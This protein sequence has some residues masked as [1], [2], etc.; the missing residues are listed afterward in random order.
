MIAKLLQRWGLAMRLRLNGPKIFGVRPTVTIGPEDFGKR[1]AKPSRFSQGVTPPSIGFIYVIR[2]EH[3]LIKV[4]SSTNPRARLAQ[5]R[6]A[7]PFPLAIDYLGF[8]RADLYVDV[9][10]T[11]H[12]ILEDHRVNLEWFDCD[13][14]IAVAAIHRAAYRLGDHV[15]TTDPDKTEDLLRAASH[16]AMTDP[17]NHHERTWI[18]KIMM[19]LEVWTGRRGLGGR[20]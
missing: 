13:S 18:D 3:G 10:K 12:A 15:V 9:E 4:G 6:T 20:P 1:M 19:T 8:T 17:D 7:S 16:Q 14:D 11:A 2:G 5:L